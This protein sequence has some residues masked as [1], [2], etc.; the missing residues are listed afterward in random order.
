MEMAA[1]MMAIKGCTEKRKTAFAALF[2][3]L[4]MAM[5]GYYLTAGYGAYLDADMSSELALAQHLAEEGT[6]I[7][8]QWQYSTEV[9]VLNTQLVFTPLMALFGFDWQLVRALGCITL[10]ILMAA[11]GVF[12]ARMIGARMCYALAFAGISVLPISVVYAQMIVIGAYYVPHAIL[13]NLTI[14]L[15]ACAIRKR[16]CGVCLTLLAALSLVMGASSIR[17]LLCAFIPSAA[18]GVWMAVFPRGEKM[19]AAERRLTAVSLGSAALSAVGYIAGQKLLGAWCSFDGARYNG[20]RLAALTNVNLFDVLDGVLDGLIKLMGFQEGRIMLS[21]QGLLSVGALGLLALSIL[22]CLRT[23]KADSAA[24][25]D[26]PARYGLLALMF[27]A[28]VTLFTFVFVEELYL[29]RY[30]LPV[31]TLGGPVMAMCLSR[32]KRCA[33]RVLSLAAFACVMLGLSAVQIRSSMANPEIGEG[34]WYNAQVVRESGVKLGY[35]TFWN[36]NVMT[37]LT[38][39]EVEVV[40]MAIARNAQDQGYPELSVWLETKENLVESRPQEAVFLL[41]GEDEAQQLEDFLLTCGAQKRPLAGEWLQ[42]HVVESQQ[43]FFE[44]MAQ[45]ESIR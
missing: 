15:T 24:Q 40:G 44:V 5:S 11:S 33:L 8:P 2:L 35:A 6:L 26:V 45:F 23:A 28:A 10:L 14:G 13:T 41:L 22:L 18:A 21:I 12:C 32:E 29:N 1:K 27:S 19:D 25:A 34:D 20:S 36:A 43:R 30:W 31:M 4:C 17:Y 38:D 42:M 37:E 3:L 39:G 16:R 7:S 9:R